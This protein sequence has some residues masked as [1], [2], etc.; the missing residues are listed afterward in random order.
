MLFLATY[1]LH[2]PLS[3]FFEVDDIVFFIP[4]LRFNAMTG[5]KVKGLTPISV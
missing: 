1:F 4:T 5:S 3:Y 2:T